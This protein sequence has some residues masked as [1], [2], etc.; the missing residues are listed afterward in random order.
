MT[1]IGPGVLRDALRW[2]DGWVD[3]VVMSVLAPDW[4]RHHGHPAGR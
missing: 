3:A 4:A 1:T 2:D